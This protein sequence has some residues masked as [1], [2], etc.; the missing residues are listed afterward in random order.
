M[1]LRFF[2]I[3]LNE[4]YMAQEELNKF[5]RSHR[6]LQADR[7]FS[8][9]QGGY[10]AVAVE[11]MDG[12]PVDEATPAARSRRKDVDYE[13]ILSPEEFQRFEAYRQIRAKISKEKGLRAYLVFTNAE[14]AEMAKLPVLD[15]DSLKTL[16]NI[17]QQRLNDYLHFFYTSTEHETEG[18]SYSADNGDKEP[19]GGVFESRQGEIF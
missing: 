5:L 7:V 19:A 9:D 14:L 8:S 17:S 18:K 6:I 2:K 11:Y 1:Q 12:D 16:K 4:I 15:S 3:P 13:K 10:W